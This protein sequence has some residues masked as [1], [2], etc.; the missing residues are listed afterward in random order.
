M[1]WD[2]TYERRWNGWGATH[3][4]F[5]LKSEA[6]QFLKEKLGQTAPLKNAT[7]EQALQT[8]PDSKLPQHSCYS[9]CA[10]T[11]LRHARGQSFPDWLAMKSGE[12]IHFP[13]AVAFP[14]SAD[15][16]RTLLSLAHHHGYVLIPYGGGTSVVGHI[17]PIPDQRPIITVSLARMN[18]LI[19]IDKDSLLATFGA[20]TPGPLVESQLQLNGYTLGHYPQS[21]ELSTLGGWVATRSSGQQSLHYGR[22]EQLFVGGMLETFDGTIHMSPHPAS[23]AGPDWRQMV[24]GSEGQLGILSEIIVKVRALPEQEYFGVA[25]LPSWSQ[26]VQCVQALAQQG[27]ALSMLRLSNPQETETQLKLATGDTQNQLLHRYLSFRGQS[28]TPC[29]LTYGLTGSDVQVRSSKAQFKNLLKQHQGVNL[30]KKLGDF[31]KEKRFNFPYLRETLWELGYAVDTLETAISWQHVP[32]LVEAIETNLRHG[33]DDMGEKVHVFTHLSHVYPDGASIYTTYLFKVSD[34][35]PATLSRWQRLK[36]TTSQL[37][38]DFRGT[39]SHQH[40]VGLDHIPYMTQEKSMP[41]IHA[42]KASRNVFDPNHQ[43][44]PGKLYPSYEIPND[45]TSE[46]GSTRIPQSRKASV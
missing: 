42:L 31:W 39:I 15:E 29:M 21:F 27:I 19:D 17:N 40:G 44:N 36:S 5:P 43:L 37:I 28:N 23:A 16:I 33:L 20:G 32:A 26:A 30:S 34:N 45:H 8:I 1:N 7:L 6:H 10:E 12:L 13:D 41:V 25:F 3:I 14:E 2:H 18:R 35:Y 46:R 24:L 11:R 4:S 38:A 9:I 22:I